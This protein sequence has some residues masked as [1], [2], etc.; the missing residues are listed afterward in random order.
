[1]WGCG[2]RV[3]V[4]WEGDEGWVNQDESQHNSVVT[5]LGVSTFDLS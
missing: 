1:M 2:G 5:Q 4:G 3:V